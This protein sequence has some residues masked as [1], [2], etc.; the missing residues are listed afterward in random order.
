LGRGLQ[1]LSIR[2]ISNLKEEINIVKNANSYWATL[3]NFSG[4]DHEYI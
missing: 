4:I 1:A 2:D 3:M